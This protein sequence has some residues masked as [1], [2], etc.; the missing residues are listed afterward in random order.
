MHTRNFFLHPPR[1]KE[2]GDV[3]TVRLL[4][5][6]TEYRYGRGNITIYPRVFLGMEQE[7]QHSESRATYCTVLYCTRYLG[8]DCR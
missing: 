3:D 8:T 7:H 5:V 4:D 2:G 6:V 1:A